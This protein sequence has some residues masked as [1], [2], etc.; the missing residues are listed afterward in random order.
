M[1]IQMNVLIK[2]ID[3][4]NHDYTNVPTEFIVDSLL[5]NIDDKI[6]DLQLVLTHLWEPVTISSI[7]LNNILTCL[8]QRHP[9]FKIYLLFNSWFKSEEYIK[10]QYVEDILYIDYFLYRMWNLIV[11]KQSNPIAYRWIPNKKQKKF[12]FLTGD[13]TRVNR[14]RLLYKFYQSNLLK[15]SIW[16]FPIS[17]DVDKLTLAKLHQILPELTTNELLTFIKKCRNKPDDV[18]V[19]KN[20]KE[21]V[22]FQSDTVS[23]SPVGPSGIPYDVKLYTNSLFSVVSESRFNFD[24]NPWITE[25]TW[26]PIINRRPFIIANSTNSLT[27]LQKMGF[28]TF[29]EFL[30]VPDYDQIAD[31]E[32]RLDA[33]VENTQH[34]LDTIHAQSK[35]IIEYV[36][37]N[38]LNLKE[39]YAR[40]IQK[41]D[42]FIKKNNL[43]LTK[44][45]LV[46]IDNVIIFSSNYL[47]EVKQLKN[48]KIQALEDYRF[49]QFYETTRA[50]WWPD[51][52]TEKDFNLLPQEIQIELCNNHG[53]IPKSSI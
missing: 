8:K 52:A 19:N 22:E 43:A 5:S 41:I 28:L 29:E 51:C 18:N 6:T 2:R 15:K 26:L 40:N 37:H 27:K 33:I 11:E 36:E 49:Y 50:V 13:P 14:A 39:N 25:K 21:Y 48:I 9:N 35:T 17:N 1:R 30:K 32:L 16:S 3:H 10:P 45:E 24:T 4:I 7:K 46:I 20:I 34:W 42:A 23:Y 38:F 12:L 44:D 47:N 53:Y 31:S